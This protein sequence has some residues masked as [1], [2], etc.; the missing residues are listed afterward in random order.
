MPKEMENKLVIQDAE[1]SEILCEILFTHYSEKFKKNYVLFYEV[2]DEDNEEIE[3]M[4]ASYEEGK[5]GDGQLDPIESDEEW[6]YIEDLLEAFSSED[7]DDECEC[8]CEDDEEC[9]C[10][11]QEHQHQHKH[12]K[13]E[14]KDGE[15]CECQE[16]QHRKGD[17]VCKEK[18]QKSECKEK[19]KEHKK[20]GK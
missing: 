13:G 3:V 4:A 19:H 5:E 2:A 12:K 20:C 10:G 7:E 17:A 11:C 9:E 16:H 6:V 8:D 1:G 18:H 14:C 15:E